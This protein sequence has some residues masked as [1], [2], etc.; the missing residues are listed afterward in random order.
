MSPL[1][2]AGRVNR[3]PGVANVTVIDQSENQGARIPPVV[4]DVPV[5]LSDQR[6][7]E[8]HCAALIRRSRETLGYMR[9][10][11]A[12]GAERA[13]TPGDRPRYARRHSRC[14]RATE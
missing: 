8:R 1:D 4:T 5:L 2:Q 12:P 10:A 11:D 6:V 9:V 14:D 3:A 13:G 7:E